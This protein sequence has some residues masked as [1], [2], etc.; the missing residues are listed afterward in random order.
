MKNKGIL[1]DTRQ[2]TR[3]TILAGVVLVLAV[4]SFAGYYYYD[5]YYSQPQAETQE[6][7]VAHA[8]QAVRDD[9]TS[10]DKRMALA[11]VYMLYQR[12]QDAITQAQ[13]VLASEPD[14][15]RGWLVI[16]VA[17]AN[18]GKPSDAID[19]LTRFVDARKDEEMPGLDKS[20]QAAA[21]YLGD[22]YLQLGKPQE[23]IEPLTQ[24]VN[25]SQTD[26]DAMYKLGMAY[27]AVQ[28]YP[29]AVNMFSA[30]TTFVPDFLEAYDAMALAYDAAGKP[31]YGDYARGMSAYSKKDYQAAIELLSKS[32]QAQPGFA[33]TF[34]GLGMAYE[35]LGNLQEAITA[36][37]T[38][39]Q[40]DPN[41][42]TASRGV[43]RVE[44]LINK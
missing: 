7:S 11:E 33:P 42:F 5:R 34:A 19:P 41:N 36:Y 1:S 44:K 12:Y 27:A 31:D 4:I 29:N 38:A 21:Y 17:S 25:W 35:A 24:A 30:A 26:A 15:Q 37:Q 13:Q 2:V 3:I 18:T 6:M 23:A 8:E 28:D 10:L 20:L 39:V 16:G 40:L 32:A 14:N 43:E 22:S 9:P